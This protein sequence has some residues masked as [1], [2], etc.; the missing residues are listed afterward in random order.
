MEWTDFTWLITQKV[1]RSCECDKELLG[2]MKRGDFLIVFQTK[3]LSIN[4]LQKMS[5]L[6]SS[7]AYVIHQKALVQYHEYVYFLKELTYF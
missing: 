5:C 6:N 2:S 4:L 3:L 1:L 7:W